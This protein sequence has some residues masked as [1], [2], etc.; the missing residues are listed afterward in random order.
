[1]SQI[2]ESSCIMWLE[3]V[4]G[5]S[6][7]SKNFLDFACCNR[8]VYFLLV[9]VIDSDCKVVRTLKNVKLW[10]YTF[11]W[12]FWI[13]CTIKN[14]FC[15]NLR[16][17]W[18]PIKCMIS[19]LILAPVKTVYM[20]RYVVRTKSVIFFR[21]NYWSYQRLVTALEKEMDILLGF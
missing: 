20:V 15:A 12:V 13:V 9:I 6:R 1:M 4:L 16:F 10:G 11:F 3:H 7:K 2:G 8:V 14:D 17:F 5:K 21:D 18:Q 19:T